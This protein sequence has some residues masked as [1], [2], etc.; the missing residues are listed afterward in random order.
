MRLP[1]GLRVLV[2]AV[3]C[4]V[5]SKGVASVEANAGHKTFL[6]AVLTMADGTSKAV[7]LEG[8]GCATSMCS[9]VR[10]R[11]NSS[12]SI[13]LDGLTSIHQIHDANGAIQATFIFKNGKE[14][15]GSIVQ[16]NRVLY[17]SR[18]LDSPEKVD[19][20]RVLRIDFGL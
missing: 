17:V 6:R 15:E 14:R 9:R 5:G 11:E 13:W 7:T 8:V 1:L 4:F 3:I 12:D 18:W 10:A 20:A 19:L 2:V 16:D